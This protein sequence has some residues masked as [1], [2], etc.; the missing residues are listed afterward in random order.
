MRKKNFPPS[1]FPKTGRGGVANFSNVRLAFPQCSLVLILTRGCF[2]N[3]PGGLLRAGMQS[4]QGRIEGLIAFVS[5]L[6]CVLNYALDPFN[7]RHCNAP[8]QHCNLQSIIAFGVAN[9]CALQRTIGCN[10]LNTN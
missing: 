1:Q 5:C 9:V 3:S 2:P 10:V 4:N 7:L 6:G 8:F